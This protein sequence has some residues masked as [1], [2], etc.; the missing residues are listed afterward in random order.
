MVDMRV[1]A[2]KVYAA[3][4]AFEALATLRRR[5]LDTIVRAAHRWR[6]CVPPSLVVLCRPV[7]GML[8]ICRQ[9]NRRPP[10]LLFLRRRTPTSVTS[11][12]IPLSCMNVWSAARHIPTK[13]PPPPHPDTCVPCPIYQQYYHH[14]AS[15]VHLCFTCT[16]VLFVCTFTGGV[17]GSAGRRRH[18]ARPAWCAGE[19]AAVPQQVR[20]AAGGGQC[21]RS[22]H[23]GSGVC[24]GER[25]RG[26]DAHRR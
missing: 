21:N 14:C 5:L 8:P 10:P 20:G 15:L 12:T 4:P 9:M 2:P 24:G 6:T 25:H 7:H 19:P 18:T 13:K 11:T 26:A 3:N 22:V 16:R 17:Q 23:R 1:M